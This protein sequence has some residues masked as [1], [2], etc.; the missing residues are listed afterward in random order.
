MAGNDPH[1]LEIEITP[2][3]KIV[4]IVKGVA[5]PNCSKL[6]A[7]LD[8]L[9]EVEVDRHTPDFYKSANQNLNVKR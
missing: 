7:W 8:E 5:G 3:G 2:E 4:S 6:T 1:T 9:G